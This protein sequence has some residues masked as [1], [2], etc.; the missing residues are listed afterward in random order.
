MRGVGATPV[1]RTSRIGS[2]ALVAPTPAT[3][4]IQKIFGTDTER[5]HAGYETYQLSIR[6]RFANDRNLIHRRNS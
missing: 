4:T 6:S 3:S 1:L 5:I 2:A